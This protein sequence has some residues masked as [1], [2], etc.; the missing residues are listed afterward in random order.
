MTRI[1]VSDIHNKKETAYA[2]YANSLK[3]LANRARKEMVYTGNLKY[4][5]NAKRVYQKEYDQLMADLNKAELNKTRERAAQRMSRAEVDAKT[6][7]GTIADGD[8]KKVGQQTVSRYRTELGSVAR[9]DRNIVIT[10]REWEAIQAGAIT[11]SKPKRILNNTDPDKLR[12]RAMPKSTSTLSTA[13]VNKIK[14]MSDSNFTLAQ[15]AE[16]CGCSVSTVS[17]YLKGVN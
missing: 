11:E 5:P 6:E 3:A 4:D 15:I 9:R 13:K 10:D 12:E 1:L 17:K 8:R 2:D 14:R 16:A 7:A